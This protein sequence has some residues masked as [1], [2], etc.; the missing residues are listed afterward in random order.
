MAEGRVQNNKA[1]VKPIGFTVK[2]ITPAVFVTGQ[3]ES[4]PDAKAAELTKLMN[5]LLAPGIWK[6][7]EEAFFA[8]IPVGTFILVDNPDTDIKDFKVEIVTLIRKKQ[9]LA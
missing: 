2:T 1:R 8:G 4:R 3:Y 7:K 6:S 9:E 5:G